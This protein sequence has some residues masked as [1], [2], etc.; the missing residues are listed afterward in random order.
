MLGV[1][2]GMLAMLL[3]LSSELRAVQAAPRGTLLILGGAFSWALGTVLMKRYPVGLPITALTAWQLLLGGVPMYVGA[4]AFELHELHPLTPGPAIAFAYNVVVAFIFCYWAWFKIVAAVPVGAS[5]LSVLMIPVV[6][7]FSGM[8]VL[9][10]VPR[11][12]DYAALALVLAALAT[13]MLPPGS[14]RALFGR[15]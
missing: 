11:W 3:L 13:V 4:L 12:Q 7:V 6:G 2:L 15:K 10:E 1:A 8:L 5:S 14:V 9:G